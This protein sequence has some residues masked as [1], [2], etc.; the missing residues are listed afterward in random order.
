MADNGGIGDQKEKGRLDAAW[1]GFPVFWLPM[2]TLI[3]VASVH[4]FADWFLWKY[5]PLKRQPPFRR[6][7]G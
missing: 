4:K 2:V 7:R 5:A 3:G 6:V 1:D